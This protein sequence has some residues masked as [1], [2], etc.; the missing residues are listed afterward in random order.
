MFIS[1]SAVRRA[2]S[3]LIKYADMQAAWNDISIMTPAA[4]IKNTLYSKLIT[5]DLP[6]RIGPFEITESMTE[7][8]AFRIYSII[9]T[10]ALY[11][12]ME[13]LQ[14]KFL[15]KFGVDVI[16]CYSTPSIAFKIFINNFTKDSTPVNK[17]DLGLERAIKPSYFVGQTDY[18]HKFGTN[19]IRLAA[20]MMLIAYILPLLNGLNLLMLSTELLI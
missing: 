20:G 7:Y 2:E 9:D 15:S 18:Y 16:N 14:A 8:Q 11:I 4:S 6:T 13:A 12:A 3:K 1:W 19:L 5:K 17:L 10:Y